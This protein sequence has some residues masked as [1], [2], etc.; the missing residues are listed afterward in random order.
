MP[1]ELTER[2]FHNE[3]WKIFLD[4]LP[5]QHDRDV[6]GLQMDWMKTTYSEIKELLDGALI[7]EEITEK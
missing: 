7:W 4:S 3:K 2:K 5:N 6:A 1:E